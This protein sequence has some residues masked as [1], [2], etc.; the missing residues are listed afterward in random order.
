MPPHEGCTHPTLPEETLG[1]IT[2]YLTKHEH[3]NQ[4]QKAVEEDRIYTTLDGPTRKAFDQKRRT[5]LGHLLPG[6]PPYDI[7]QRDRLFQSGEL[8]DRFWPEIEAKKMPL[9]T[10]VRL[11]RNARAYMKEKRC[12]GREAVEAVYAEYLKLPL[13]KMVDGTVI[14]KR[15]AGRLRRTTEDV[16]EEKRAR[17]TEKEDSGDATERELWLR[18]RKAISALAAAK[19][20]SI[21]EG[22]M[23]DQIVLGMERDV[24]VLFE[25]WSNKIH[26]QKIRAK[27]QANVTRLV[28]RP[29]VI[30]ACRALHMDPPKPGEPVDMVLAKRQKKKLAALY[31]PDSNAGDETTRGMY[32]RVLA[33]YGELEEF[34]EQ[35]FPQYLNTPK[36]QS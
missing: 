31:H 32:E 15:T 25:E 33:A 20:Q 27:E 19:L 6:I 14:H 8:A 21:P 9:S 4:Y 7:D 26:R 24:K 29:T 22:I 18:V 3:W 1:L 28:S 36:A 17:R 11:V 30:E 35:A 10:G 34:M 16:V 5:A 12:S 13:I 2:E 23:K